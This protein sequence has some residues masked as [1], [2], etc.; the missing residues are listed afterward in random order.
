MADISFTAANIRPLLGSVTKPVQCGEAVGVGKPVYIKS[1]GKA[2]LADAAALVSAQARGVCVAVSGYGKLV[3]VADD[4][5]DVTFFGPIA[6]YTSLTPG[7][8]LYA[9]ATAGNIEAAIPAAT[10]YKWVIASALSA[11]VIF[12]SP[13]TDDVAVIT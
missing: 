2:W 3:S 9:S 7:Q 5:I 4:M 12:V 10:N 8:D 1:D 6:G 13:Y 11:G